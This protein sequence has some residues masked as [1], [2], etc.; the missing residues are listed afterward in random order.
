[1]ARDGSVRSKLKKYNGQRHEF[2]GFV[3]KIT[4]GNNREKG[5]YK[6][7]MLRDIRFVNCDTLITNHV[8]IS[9]PSHFQSIFFNKDDV[10]G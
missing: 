9:V 4:A 6:N 2:W 1:M 8:W 5:S 3:E 10:N 7:L